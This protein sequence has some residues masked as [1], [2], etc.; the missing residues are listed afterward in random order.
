MSCLKFFW[1]KKIK[2]SDFC[3]FPQFDCNTVDN[4]NLSSTYFY[5]A[6][7]LKRVS[8]WGHS[9]IFLIIIGTYRFAHNQEMPFLI[10]EFHLKRNRFKFTCMLNIK[11]H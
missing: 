3:N 5:L 7:L 11:F 10:V 8:I 4:S 9:H 1:G 6:K 2:L